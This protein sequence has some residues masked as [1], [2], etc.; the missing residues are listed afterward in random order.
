[1]IIDLHFHT[2]TYSPCSRIPLEKGLE[3]AASL[4][5]DAI[6]L[7]EHDIFHGYRDI[8]R[9]EK[10]YGIR[11]FTGV[12][13]FTAQGD[14]LCFGLDRIP[15]G[16]VQAR[17]LVSRLGEE[18]GASIAAH[19]FRNNDRGVKELILDLP[20]LTAVEAWN[21]NT[22]YLNNLKAHVMAESGGIP[23]TGASDSH[24]LEKIGCFATEFGGKVDTDRDLIAVLR[25]GDFRPVRYDND[26]GRFAE[27]LN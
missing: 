25:S 12:E 24:R 6:C 9:L 26:T 2:D 23:V 27:I 3:R 17:D 7:T 13:I 21:G 10:R 19:P 1:M 22:D 4:G 15:G 14:I 8:P 5:L 18:G 11:V 20:G 16:T